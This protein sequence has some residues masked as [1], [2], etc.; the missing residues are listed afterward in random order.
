LAID[1]PGRDHSRHRSRH[2]ALLIFAVAFIFANWLAAR[3][4]LQQIGVGFFWVLLTVIFEIT[5]VF[6]VVGADMARIRED[7][8][9]PNGG[10]MPIG[11]LFMLCTPMLASWLRSKFSSVS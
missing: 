4:M 10:L 3:S 9:L 1:H 5:L 7:Y 8:D 6:F 11:L 2:F